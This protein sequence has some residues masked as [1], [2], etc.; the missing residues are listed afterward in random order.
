MEVA[1]RRCGRVEREAAA[2][3]RLVKRGPGPPPRTSSHAC[4]AAAVSSRRLSGPALLALAAHVDR[5]GVQVDVL[6]VELGDLGAAQA[7]IPEQAQ[8]GAIAGAL[9]VLTPEA[10]GQAAGA[11]DV[12]ATGVSVVLPL[13]A[14]HVQG[15]GDQVKAA[16]QAGQADQGPQGREAPVDGGSLQPPPAQVT[17]VVVDQLVGGPGR[18][19][20]EQLLGGLLG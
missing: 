8:D 10:L 2:R 6:E 3:S 16:G 17:D 1:L 7:Q 12:G 14:G 19:R 4:R 20:G 15:P 9:G 5:A 13:L 11:G 18:G